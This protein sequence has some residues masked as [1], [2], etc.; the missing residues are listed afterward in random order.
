MRKGLIT[1]GLVGLA[2]M[3]GSSAFA[4]DYPS[5]PLT[6]A[7]ATAAGSTGAQWC[8]MVSEILSKP[9]ILGQPV[10]VEL[11]PGGS[12][13]EAAIYLTQRPADGYTLLQGSQSYAGYVNL[14]TFTP[15]LDDMEFLLRVEKFIY[16]LGVPADSEFKTFDDAV[17]YAKEHPGE[18]GIGGNKIGSVHHR[19]ILDAFGAAGAEINYIPY[20]GS[21]DA[22]RDTLGKHIPVGLGSIGQWQQHVNSGAIRILAVLNDERVSAWPDAPS[23]KELGYDYPVTHNFMAIIVK[24]GTPDDVKQKLRDAFAKL[25]ESDEYKAYLAQSPH[26]VP[27]FNA[28]PDVVQKEW[29]DT[30]SGTKE[31]MQKAGMI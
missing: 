31:F 11:K 15:K 2:A 1:A 13:N 29:Q 16:A 8:Q 27:W 19:L 20:E 26:V 6:I 10:N 30:V 28:D 23:I 18:L 17:K 5:K 9:D 3:L 7:C 25:V 12:G 14:P 24:T 21:A 22:V 4:E